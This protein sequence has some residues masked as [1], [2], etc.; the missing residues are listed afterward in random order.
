M[1][2]KRIFMLRSKEIK[3]IVLSNTNLQSFRCAIQDP[4]SKTI[5]MNNGFFFFDWLDF[6][7]GKIAFVSANLI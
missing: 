4:S 7:K 6:S 3:R 2:T 5:V 1:S